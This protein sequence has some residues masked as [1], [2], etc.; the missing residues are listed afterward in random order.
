MNIFYTGNIHVFRNTTQISFKQDFP[1]GETPTS[2]AGLFYKFFYQ[3]LHENERIWTRWR[4][5][6]SLALPLIRQCLT[7]I[8]VRNPQPEIHQ[9]ILE[10]ALGTHAPLGTI[11]F[12]FKLFLAKI[13][14]NNE[15]LS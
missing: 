1:Q 5:G 4:G 2:K 12:I 14:P 15:F 10:G 13:M 9:R 3:K 6:A 11:Y 8:F 7:V